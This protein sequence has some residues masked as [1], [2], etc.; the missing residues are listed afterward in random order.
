MYYTVKKKSARII[1]E[2]W[3]EDTDTYERMLIAI[4]HQRNANISYNDI[5]KYITRRIKIKSKQSK[6]QEITKTRKLKMIQRNGKTPLF[7][8]LEEL[9]LL[10]CPYYPNIVQI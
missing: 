1:R 6:K 4:S 8:G 7:L 2:T 9:I 5:E 10:K 3:Q